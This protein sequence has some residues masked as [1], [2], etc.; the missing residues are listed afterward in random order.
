MTP[1]DDA[2][3]VKQ[4]LAGD[5]DAFG[6][7]VRRHQD[8]V[9]CL[10]YQRLRDRAEAEDACQ[11]AFLRA[12][13]NLPKLRS[14]TRFASWLYSIGI[15]AAREHLRRRRPMIPFA[16]V[17]EPEVSRPEEP[18]EERVDEVLEALGKLAPKYR[19]PLTLRYVRGLKY[20][21]IAAVLHI[22]AVSVRSRVHR[23]KVMLRAKLGA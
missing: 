12:Y 21:E 7:L 11:E 1:L 17:P 14:P 20:E 23:A 5:K 3:L 4:S 6:V 16:D 10:V 13:R 18:A 19:I 8:V 9:F 2:E 15:N 22:A